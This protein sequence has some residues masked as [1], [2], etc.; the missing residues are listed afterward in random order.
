MPESPTPLSAS[1]AARFF[2]QHATAYGAV[3]PVSMRTSKL[4]SHGD[5]V[6]FGYRGYAEL[7]GKRS[8]IPLTATLELSRDRRRIAS[9]DVTIASGP[10]A[11]LTLVAGAP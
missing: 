1:G 7:G 8:S 9:Y 5:I 6:T 2:L 10:F 4:R 11:G 3:M